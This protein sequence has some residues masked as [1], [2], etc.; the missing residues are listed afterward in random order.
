MI[1]S[2]RRRRRRFAG[3]SIAVVLVSGCGSADDTGGSGVENGSHQ[4]VATTSIWADIVSG[5]TCRGDL[6]IEVTS[7]IPPRSDPHG[8]EPSLQDRELLDDAALVVANGA[9]L[10]TGADALLD[11][12]DG[13]RVVEVA[14]LP[15]LELRDATSSEEDDQ[16]E[17]D[18]GDI[19]P[20]LWLDPSL[21]ADAIGPIADRV[22]AT[23]GAD[24]TAI[25]RCVDAYRSEL[26]TLDD[27]IADRIDAV[28]AA[29]RVLVTNHDAYGY[30]ADRYGLEVVGT[31]IPS[32]STMAETNA[33][34]LEELAAVVEREA[35]PAIFVDSDQD[36]AEADELA[37]TLDV[38][39]VRL[40]TDSLGDDDATD[41]YVELMR[42]DADAV[43]SALGG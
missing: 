13:A 15:G 17:D 31:V 11:D 10:E 28:P 39:V 12:L 36:T 6:G 22:I 4:I 5:V 2:L 3:G 27:E 38:E 42:T 7:L 32:T 41:T 8:Y 40:R 18:H 25:E 23:T 14:E 33:A 43:A 24:K 1:L 21:V 26:L 35:V 19:D 9:S 29:R 30:F 34:D 20:H 37:A 16:T